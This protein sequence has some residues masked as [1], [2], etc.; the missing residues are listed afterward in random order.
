MTSIRCFLSA[1][2]LLLPVALAQTGSTL[3]SGFDTPQSLPTIGGQLTGGRDLAFANSVDKY[4]RTWST[5]AVTGG[6]TAATALPVGGAVH[7]YFPKGYFDA[8]D[9]SKVN[10]FTG[11]STTFTCGSLNKGSASDAW[12]RFSCVIAGSALSVGSQVFSFTAGF[13]K[14][15]APSPSSSFKVETTVDSSVSALTSA[16]GGVITIGTFSGSLSTNTQN[17]AAVSISF[18]TA[19]PLP[20][21]GSVTFNMPANYLASVDTTMTNSFKDTAVKATCSLTK[22]TGSATIDSV[23]CITSGADLAVGSQTFIFSVNSITGGVPTPTSSKFTVS[24]S[25]DRISGEASVV[26]IGGTI[27][28]DNFASLDPAERPGQLN[29][30]PVKFSLTDATAVPVGGVITIALPPKYFSAVDSSKINTWGDVKASCTLK[31]GV[32]GTKVLGFDGYDTVLCTTSGS[33]SV[34][35]A[36]DF[37]FANSTVTFGTP[38]DQKKFAVATTV[39][40][41]SADKLTAALGGSVTIGSA[42]TFDALPFTSNAVASTNTTGLKFTL[43]TPLPQGGKIT[44]SLPKGYFDK[45]DS[46]KK[47]TFNIGSS[48]AQCT[49]SVGSS[50]GDVSSPLNGGDQVICTVATADL[51]NSENVLQFDVGQVTMGKATA[52]VTNGLQVE[53]TLDRRASSA[54]N[55]GKIGDQLPTEKG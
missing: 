20:I 44:I 8:I 53:T 12:D 49:L 38:Q 47:A 4:P 40:L 25:T 41:V 3:D 22:A 32:P 13:V 54:S 36:K 55:A 24:T 37:V 2:L 23:V 46:S 51:S 34:K 5:G 43:A 45:V 31:S 14:T 11:G 6:F 21:G 1:A 29:V 27:T 28:I 42:F 48:T 10:T 16:I 39:D 50:Y 26:A 30:A 19:T 7:F 52:A 33:A 18:S 9:T 17:A 15:G 35:S